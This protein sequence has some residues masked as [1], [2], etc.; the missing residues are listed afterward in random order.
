MLADR[1]P[2]T[3]YSE[4]IES[5]LAKIHFS[6][7]THSKCKQRE[8]SRKPAKLTYISEYILI[9]ITYILHQTSISHFRLK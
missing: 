8:H 2:L 3:V 1:K 6:L 9:H 5:G 4:L 7:A